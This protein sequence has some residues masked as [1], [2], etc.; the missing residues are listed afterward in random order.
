M[1]CLSLYWG[2]S[3]M[4]WLRS[5]TVTSF[6]RMN[7]DWHVRVWTG[8]STTP[9]AWNTS[10]QYEQS[11]YKGRDWRDTLDVEW[12]SIDFDGM[13]AVQCSDLTR[14]KVLSE[15][16]LWSDFDIIYLEPIDAYLDTLSKPSLTC[17]PHFALGLCGG[18]EP[19]AAIYERALQMATPSAY[20][21][22]GVMPLYDLA[23]G[24]PSPRQSDDAHARLCAR[25]GHIEDIPMPW[26]HPHDATSVHERYVPLRTLG[27]HWYGG[28]ARSQDMSALLTPDNV[29]Q[30]SHTSFLAEAVTRIL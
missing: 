5:L 13:T 3:P 18:G 12:C 15:G 16:G 20:Q 24:S 6:Q 1:K 19:F 11:H 30:H 28:L 2:D 26:V 25:V 10:E 29:W 27:Y 17:S 8:S 7:P 21:S 4:S 23:F 14:W 9:P 22:A